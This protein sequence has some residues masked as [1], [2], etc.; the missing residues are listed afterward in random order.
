MKMFVRTG[1]ALMA[2]LW[3]SLNAAE[4]DKVVLKVLLSGTTPVLELN[5]DRLPVPSLKDLNP[6]TK[7]LAQLRGSSKSLEIIV[8]D[9][10]ALVDVLAAV[11]AANDAK[12]VEARYWGC[13]PPGCSIPTGAT[14]DQERLKGRNLKVSD[15]LKTVINNS[16]KC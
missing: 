7:K 12:F 16:Y 6:L 2:M 4:S 9:G 3:V 8:S 15:L 13:I 10:S 1:C 14:A 11:Q 5:G